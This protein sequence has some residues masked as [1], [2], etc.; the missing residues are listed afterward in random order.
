[1]RQI[2]LYLFI[3]CA[4][5]V[6]AEQFKITGKVVDATDNDQQ[7]I[8][9][10]VTVVGT[11]R[12]VSTDFDGNF[13][14]EVEK[15][16]ILKFSFVGFY[17]K[18]VEVLNDSSLFVEMKAWDEFCF[19]PIKHI[20]LPDNH[21]KS[22]LKEIQIL[23]PDLTKCNDKSKMLMYK[24]GSI[25]FSMCN[26]NVCKQYYTLEKYKNE[27]LESVYH[28]FAKSFKG[29]DSSKKNKSGKEITFYYPEYSVHIQY[30]PNE[31]VSVTYELNPEYYK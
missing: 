24:S 8:G 2:L 22:S 14:I 13:S 29:Y 25:M 17:S 11:H 9:A 7:L 18:V 26:G 3:L 4:C 19:C 31:R 6:S 30:E 28:S 10:S 5:S 12:G 27:V 15:D 20:V 23:F 21:L 1:M 16:E